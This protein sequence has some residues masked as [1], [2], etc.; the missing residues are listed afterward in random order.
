MS[1][2]SSAAARVAPAELKRTWWNCRVVEDDY[3][4]D[5]EV[6]E[7]CPEERAILVAS[8][9]ENGLHAPTLDFD[10]PVEARTLEF[11][12]TRLVMEAGPVRERPWRKLLG[13]MAGLGLL[14]RGFEHDHGRHGDPSSPDALAFDLS[15]PATVL[16]SSTHGHSHVY[17]GA[18]MPWSDYLKLCKALAKV[19][20]LEKGYVR[21][22][23]RRKM[24]MLFKP[25]LTK[26]QLAA[27]GRMPGALVTR[28]RGE[29]S[30]L[31]G[32]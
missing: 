21:A 23:K 18:E 2:R 32:Y 19:G 14:K 31:D 15:V 10:F 22:A 27:D 25:G 26:A 28:K 5:Y 20:L 11:G 16:P 8:L 6:R 7:R 9:T 24:T 13:L 17:L 1:Y 4:G 3:D 29:S 12:H 30:W